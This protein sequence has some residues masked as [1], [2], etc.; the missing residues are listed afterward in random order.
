M[1]DTLPIEDPKNNA[2]DHGKHLSGALVE[3]DG[4]HP[5]NDYG[6]IGDL[7]SVALVNPEG[8]IDWC[9][10]PIFDS[11][12]VFAAILDSSRGGRFSV[13]P[14][15]YNTSY[16][17]YLHSTNVLFCNFRSPSGCVSVCDY[18]PILNPDGHRDNVDQAYICRHVE[19]A[20]GVNVRVRVSFEPKPE[21]GVGDDTVLKSKYCASAPGAGLK[22]H[23]T[24]EIEWD[25]DGNSGVIV[26]SHGDS[27]RLVLQFGDAHLPRNLQAWTD[28]TLLDTRHYWETWLNQC[29][30]KGRWRRMVE[31]SALTLKLLTFKP[32][33]AIV[34]AP[35]ASLPEEIGGGRNW[36]YRFS[37]PRD[38]A[39]TLNALYLLGFSDEAE[40]YVRWLINIQSLDVDVLPI[41]YPI[42]EH[43]TTE[44]R[45]LT[46]FEGY[47]GSAPVRIGNGARYQLQLDV[48]GE[49]NDSLFLFGIY[50]G[51][52]DHEIWG[53]MREFAERICR[54]WRSKDEG[55]WEVRGGSRHFT[56]SKLMCWVGLERALRVGIENGFEGDFARWENELEEIRDYL[57]GNCLHPEGDYFV[58][59]PDSDAV[60]ASNLLIPIMSFLPGDDPRVQA[61]IDQTFEQLTIDNMVYRYQSDDGLDGDEGTFNICTFW[62]VEALAM[63]GR[64]E[65]AVTMFNHMLE[66]SSNLGLYSEETE[67][68]GRAAL[69]N[70][71]QAFSH[72][73]LIN[74]AL[75]LDGQ[76]SQRPAP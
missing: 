34:A 24:H 60:D 12:S 18:M 63:A 16:L 22:L 36:D 14:E 2:G 65:E 23:S 55:I 7:H 67:P 56:Y 27:A 35:T 46:Q 64:T 15:N 21:Y 44:E 45:E 58:Q 76:L 26:L 8:G 6:I 5:I 11:P 10:L 1:A 33:G 52:I 20:K 9:C 29:V 71:P 30:Y 68:N 70:F 39:L 32:T 43:D 3:N 47:R 61:T 62:M 41:L 17:S 53:Y 25:P 50:G 75:T 37:W 51:Q 49:V 42:T 13:A 4:Y 54:Q 19:C 57:L 59:S 69:G 40:E 74:S 28:K 66:L 73:G 31:R 48:Y 38:S 72:V